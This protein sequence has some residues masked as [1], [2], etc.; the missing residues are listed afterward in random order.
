VIV[1]AGEALIDL[2]L[3][4]DGSVTAQLGGGPFNVARTIGRL[5]GAVT[6]LGAVSYDRFGTRLYERLLADGVD[7][8]AT[9]RN[10]RPTTLAAA[11]L[12]SSGAATYRFYLVGTSA[13]ALDHVPAL[14]EQPS[15]VHMGTL[16]LVLEPMASTLLDHLESLAPSTLVML[17]PNCRVRVIDDRDRYV[18][19]MQRAYGRSHVVKISTDDAQYLAPALQPIAL[20]RELVAGGVGV[21]LLTAGGDGTWV[22]SPDAETKVPTAPITVADTIGAGDSFGGAFLA[23]WIGNGLGVE[24]LTD[25]ALVVAAT[26]A[27][28]A[29]AAFTCQQVGA[30]PPWRTDLPTTWGDR[31]AG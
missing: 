11:E 28:Q 22:V 19:T 26:S 21:V 25:H 7:T 20:A 18:A 17:D 10:D 8:S 5:G 31:P 27:A 2:V 15:A 14:A 3:A 13:P 9:V 23:W 30:E 24:G 12:D 4:V 1:V 6:F 16:G 29:V